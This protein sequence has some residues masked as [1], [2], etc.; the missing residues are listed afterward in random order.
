MDRRIPAARRGRVCRVR[1]AA[2]ARVSRTKP[3]FHGQVQYGKRRGQRVALRA[4]PPRARHMY[5]QRSTKVVVLLLGLLVAALLTYA[6]V[7]GLDP[8]QGAAPAARTADCPNGILG[9]CNGVGTCVGG[10]CVCQAGYTGPACGSTVG[11]PC[12]VD[13]AGLVCA[14]VGTCVLGACDCPAGLSGE[15]C[16]TV[17]IACPTVGGVVCDGHGT[18]AGATCTCNTGWGGRACNMQC[19]YASKGVCN[20]NGKC[21]CNSTGCVCTCNGA[22][23]TSNCA[24]APTTCTGIA[25][26]SKNSTGCAMVV[27]VVG[28]P[29]VPECQCVSQE[30]VAAGVTNCSQAP[31]NPATGH[32]CSISD[33]A[34]PGSSNSGAGVLSTG[35]DANG[36]LISQCVCNTGYGAPGAEDYC[37]GCAQDYTPQDATVKYNINYEG[38]CGACGSQGDKIVPCGANGVCVGTQCVCGG[39]LKIPGLSYFGPDCNVVVWDS[40]PAGWVGVNAGT[41][42]AAGIANNIDWLTGFA[43]AVKSASQAPVTALPTFS[44]ADT[45]RKWLLEPD[46]TK[47]LPYASYLYGPPAPPGIAAPSTLGIAIAPLSHYDA[48]L[49]DA[50]DLNYWDVEGTNVCFGDATAH[51]Y[52]LKSALSAHLYPI[53]QCA[54]HTL[55]NAATISYKDANLAENGSGATSIWVTPTTGTPAF[56]T[57]APML[58]A[59]TDAGERW[60]KAHAASNSGSSRVAVFPPQPFCDSGH[61]T[62]PSFVSNAASQ[63]SS[64]ST[65]ALRYS[66]G[67]QWYFDTGSSSTIFVQP[68]LVPVQS[69][70]QYETACTPCLFAGCVDTCIAATNSLTLLTNAARAHEDG[71]IATMASALSSFPK[72]DKIKYSSQCNVEFMAAYLDMTNSVTVATATTGPTITGVSTGPTTTATYGCGKRFISDWTDGGF[73][74]TCAHDFGSAGYCEFDSKLNNCCLVQSTPVLWDPTSAGSNGNQCGSFGATWPAPLEQ[75]SPFATL[76]PRTLP[77]AFDAAYVS[78]VVS[79]TQLAGLGCMAPVTTNGSTSFLYCDATEAEKYAQAALAGSF[80]C[81]CYGVAANRTN[82]VNDDSSPYCTQCA[83]TATAG[84][85]TGSYSASFSADEV[86]CAIVSCANSVYATGTPALTMGPTASSGAES[87]ASGTCCTTYNNCATGTY[88]TQW[89]AAAG[90]VGWSFYKNVVNYYSA[91]TWSAMTIPGTSGYQPWVGRAEDS[92]NEDVYDTS[93]CYTTIL[94]RYS[95]VGCASD[96][97]VFV[98]IPCGGQS[99]LSASDISNIYNVAGAWDRCCSGGT[100]VAN[101]LSL[102][103]RYLLNRIYAQVKGPPGYRPDASQRTPLPSYWTGPTPGIMYGFAQFPGPRKVAIYPPP[104]TTQDTACNW[105]SVFS[106]DTS[107]AE[108]DY[109]NNLFDTVR[110]STD[111]LNYWLAGKQ[112]NI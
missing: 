51:T 83:S 62:A 38:A 12:P 52:G 72:Y 21:T 64:T 99:E 28:T 92:I 10:T 58:T 109:T 57:G 22:A 61:A 30:G 108:T 48:T 34:L 79:T 31:A 40:L 2:T 75:G 37:G 90:V 110:D 15:A 23:H 17:S 100:T 33:V 44:K 19:P 20:G 36:A 14:G 4:R 18:C 9:P 5:V 47:M 80:K 70:V 11:R 35:I 102:A 77:S 73:V 69:G 65:P 95:L 25:C 94:L 85:I 67:S 105:W 81:E 111:Y 3:T 7:S 46:S 104:F 50:A 78:N 43:G 42:T 27:V 6:L 86:G 55:D 82:Y 97:Y 60:T 66:S 54:R 1:G 103:P 13:A 16:D 63:V 101:P 29:A 8:V 32:F 76:A 39:V 87:V 59:M 49:G 26:D 53:N 89:P 93:L 24:P 88:S 68:T 112:P 106:D 45:I 41:S 107:T 71:A 56:T 84:T 98:D 96:L 91:L 74:C